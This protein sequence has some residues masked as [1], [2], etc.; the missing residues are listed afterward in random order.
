VKGGVIVEIFNDKFGIDLR[1]CVEELKKHVNLVG[2]QINMHESKKP[3]HKLGFKYETMF[4]MC[5]TLLNISDDDFIKLNESAGGK[6]SN[7]LSFD[8][9]LVLSENT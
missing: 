3:W 5:Q 4:N 8:D 7:G 1:A 9:F 2:V 6:V